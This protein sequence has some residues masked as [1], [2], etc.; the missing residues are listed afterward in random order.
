MNFS[1]EPKLYCWII[2]IF[3]PP[4]KYKLIPH[5]RPLIL[6]HSPV[7]GRVTI[8]KR[9][10]N[11]NRGTRR[12]PLTSGHHLY[13]GRLNSQRVISQ[14]KKD[15]FRPG[16]SITNNLT[17]ENEQLPL[18]LGGGAGS[19]RRNRFNEERRKNK[20]N[21]IRN[22]KRQHGSRVNN[23]IHPSDSHRRRRRKKQHRGISEVPNI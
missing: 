16:N 12:G 8:P 11:H 15:R 10:Y 6:A 20:R 18:H 2:H 13:Q 22:N 17:G 21:N 4:K 5:R 9:P 7:V 3:R 19:S 1:P 14:I 23:R